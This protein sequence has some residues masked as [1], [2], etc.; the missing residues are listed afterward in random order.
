MCLSRTVFK[1][2]PHIPKFKEVTY[3][4]DP[5]H[6]PFGGNA[7]VL[8]C[9]NQHTKFEVPSFTDSKNMIGAKI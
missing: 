7:L 1:I 2:L 8:L 3:S 9:I 4:R 5:E 6:I